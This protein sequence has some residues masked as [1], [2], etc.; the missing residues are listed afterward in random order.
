MIRLSR[1]LKVIHIKVNLDGKY[2]LTPSL[3]YE[4]QV[5][6]Y[7]PKNHWTLFLK[8]GILGEYRKRFTFIHSLNFRY[9]DLTVKCTSD[10][11]DIYFQSSKM[12]F[13]GL[14]ELQYARMN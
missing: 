10:I 5:F 13:A 11:Y 2:Q 4:F 12:T 1:L 9:G 3:I 7:H 8:E 6:S 14:G